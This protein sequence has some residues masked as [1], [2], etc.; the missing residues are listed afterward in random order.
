M[1]G[2]SLTRSIVSSTWSSFRFIFGPMINGSARGPNRCQTTDISRI[3]Q[4]THA[5]THG[6]ESPVVRMHVV[7]AGKLYV[8]VYVL[9]RTRSLHGAILCDVDGY[10]DVRME[11]PKHNYLGREI[12]RRRRRRRRAHGH[13]PLWTNISTLATSIFPLTSQLYPFLRGWMHFTWLTS[14]AAARWHPSP[15]PSFIWPTAVSSFQEFTCHS[16]KQ[17]PLPRQ[18]PATG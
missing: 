2:F 7:L 5:Y 18:P 3:D 15:P 10:G 14:P 8:S 17:P 13:K 9:S 11:T 16:C 1:Q 6:G 4:V 12:F